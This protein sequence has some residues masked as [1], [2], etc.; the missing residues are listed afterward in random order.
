MDNLEQDHLH[1]LELAYSK[2][3]QP[4][5]LI[6]YFGTPEEF[7]EWTEKGTPSDL[8]ACLLAFE[9]EELYDHCQVIKETL[10]QKDAEAN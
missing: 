5:K 9:R 3:I 4:T 2:L 6:E 1:A 7:K 8:R 10:A